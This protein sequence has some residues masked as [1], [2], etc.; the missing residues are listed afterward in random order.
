M[1]QAQVLQMTRRAC[2]ELEA[3]VRAKGSGLADR[4]NSGVRGDPCAAMNVSPKAWHGGTAVRFQKW[5]DDQLP[6]L[7]SPQDSAASVGDS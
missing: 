5:V 2:V 1:K 6:E 7:P 4:A 3:V